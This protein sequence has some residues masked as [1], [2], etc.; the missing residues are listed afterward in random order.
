MSFLE[1]MQYI[2]FCSVLF[3][4]LGKHYGRKDEGRYDL[5]DVISELFSDWI[6]QFRRRIRGN[7]ADPAS[8]D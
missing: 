1:S 8:S 3:M 6:V 4:E 7:A 2:Y 5:F